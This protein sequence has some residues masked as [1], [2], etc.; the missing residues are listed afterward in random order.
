MPKRYVKHRN[1]D[2]KENVKL[3]LITHDRN[4]RV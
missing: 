4:V 2:W 1:K 3:F